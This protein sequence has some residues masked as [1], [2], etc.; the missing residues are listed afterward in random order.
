[1]GTGT[2][3]PEATRSGGREVGVDDL[4][5]ESKITVPAVPEWAVAR[6]RINGLVAQGALGPLTTITGPPGAGKTMALSLWAA[7]AAPAVTAWVTVDQH[8][9]RPRVFWSYVIAALRR[10]G[11]LVPTSLSLTRGSPVNHEFLLRLAAVIAGQDPP[12]V[13]ILDDLHLLTDPKALS[14]LDYVLKNGVPG[15]RLVVSSRMD[16]L[17]PLHRYRLAGELTEVRAE[18]LA[19]SVTESRQLMA[20]HGIRLSPDSLESLTRRAEGWAAGVRLAAMSMDGH[21]DPEQFVKEL[22]AEDSTVAA[23]LIE[24]VLNAQ[25]PHV[26]EFMLRTSILDRVS[27]D[28]ADVLVGEGQGA[29]VLPNLARAN[30]FVQR[31]ERGWYRY[32]SLFAAVLRLKLRREDP[33]RVPDLHRRAAWWYRR[34]GSLA[35]AVQHA[36]AAGDWQLAARTALDELAIGQLIEL[37][38]DESLA[39]GFRHMPRDLEWTEPQPLLV[40]AAIELSRGQDGLSSTLMRA[41]ETILDR[42][43]DEEEVPSRLAAALIGLALARRNGDLAAASAA[44][45]AAQTL[46]AAL[47]E[48][49]LAARPAVRSQVLAGWGAV[50]LWSGRFDEAAIVLNAAVAVS[51]GDGLYERYESL[52]HLAL[53]E[54]LQGRLGRAG[55]LAAGAAGEH[56]S[57]AS[58]S[59]G[60]VSPVSPAEELA[61]AWVNL[62]RNELSLARGWLKRAHE[63]VRTR[64]DRLISAVAGLAG[65]R[66]ALAE[67]RAKAVAEIVA[68]ARQ[69]WS[70]PAW[71]EHRLMLTESRAFMAVS[72]FTSAADV[73]TRADP[74]SWLDATVALA[75]ARLAAGDQHAAREALVSA[76]DGDEQQDPVRLAQWLVD[77]QLS[78][79]SGDHVRGRQALEQ[80]LQL[81]EADQLRLPFAMERS[82]IRPVLRRDP[83]LARAHH[84]L[85]EPGLVTAGRQKGYDA[86]AAEQAPLIVDQLSE[87]E[88]EVLRH[89]AA[90]LSTAEIAAEMYISV[91]T[92]K[93]HLRSIYRKLSATHRSEAVRRA[94]QLELI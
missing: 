8:D 57:H 93:S 71:L 80:A 48:D 20:Q 54:A 69:G 68:R 1:M 70:P 37:R 91:N 73:A 2:S 67:G 3:L 58:R 78:Y 45:D 31:E 83:D 53:L 36:A 76:P 41:A 47:P 4:V 84:R 25:P 49:L 24:E 7:G 6:P 88:R 12:V 26:R 52:G 94:Q 89:V 82:W 51:A 19:F 34:N 55:E 66:L 59:A 43:P 39:D 65:A 15:L 44:S 28:L 35:K 14:G 63:S 46:L 10:A 61:L 92:V 79:S 11:V 9:N 87:R 17:L 23:Y 77:A 85:L 30:A 56:G 72:D 29:S 62:E 74:A 33:E 27:A 18:N 21:A 86:S 13:L 42:R 5:L 90:M 64:P 60:P 75:Q 16:P 81:G 40:A 32:H 22:V 38:G 50:E